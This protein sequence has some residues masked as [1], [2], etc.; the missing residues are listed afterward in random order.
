[1]VTGAF[2]LLALFVAG[3][4]PKDL[5]EIRGRDVPLRGTVLSGDERSLTL[6][7]AL[8]QVVSIVRGRA[9]DEEFGDR[10]LARGWREPVEVSV[11]SEDDRSVTIRLPRSLL[12]RVLRGEQTGAPLPHSRGGARGRI[13]LRGKPFADAEIRVVRILEDPSALD[14]SAAVREAEEFTGRT[15]GEGRFRLTRLSPGLYRLYIRR[16]PSEPWRRRARPQA[17]LPVVAGKTT[18]LRDVVIS[19]VMP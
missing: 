4:A 17:D 5:V 14:S 18:V 13:L 1:M 2:L 9:A 12:R 6:R 19:R 10:L 8:R 7:I 16:S 11:V 3:A 15:D